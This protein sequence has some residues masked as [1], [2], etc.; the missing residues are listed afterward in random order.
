MKDVAG[1]I[2]TP[3]L[4]LEGA[5]DM[6]F[7]GQAQEV[8]DALQVSK[9]LIKFTGEDGAENHCQSGALAFKDEAVFNWLDD[10]LLLRDGRAI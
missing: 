1:Q 6:F 8:Y 10:T 3:C 9:H 7:R 4:V 5:G 2:R